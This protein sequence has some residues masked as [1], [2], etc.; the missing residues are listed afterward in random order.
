MDIRVY[1]AGNA[2]VEVTVS[3]AGGVTVPPGFAGQWVCLDGIAYRTGC[4]QPSDLHIGR[5]MIRKSNGYY[6]AWHVYPP[7]PYD[8][9]HQYGV[10]LAECKE[11]CLQLGCLSLQYYVAAA[12]LTEGAQS[13]CAVRFRDVYTAPPDV[14]HSVTVSESQEEEGT[15]SSYTYVC[16][17]SA[18]RPTWL[19]PQ[20]N[21][22][23][24]VLP[25][26]ALVTPYNFTSLQVKRPVEY[27]FTA[28]GRRE[29]FDAALLPQMAALSFAVAGLSVAVCVLL[30]AGHVLRGRTRR[31]SA[32]ARAQGW[33]LRSLRGVMSCAL[34]V[35]LIQLVLGF[36]LMQFDS[37]LQPPQRLLEGGLF[38]FV[39]NWVQAVL[40]LPL[41]VLDFVGVLPLRRS[42]IRHHASIGAVLGILGFIASHF[43][44]FVTIKEMEGQRYTGNVADGVATALFVGFTAGLVSTTSFN[45][46]FALLL[47][48]LFSGAVYGP[49]AVARLKS[50]CGTCEVLLIPTAVCQ[51]VVLG[52]A[53]CTALGLAVRL[54]RVAPDDHLVA[55]LLLRWRWQPKATSTS[56]RRP[57]RRLEQVARFLRASAFAK[58]AG[59]GLTIG[60]LVVGSLRLQG[61]T[62]LHLVGP[63]TWCPVKVARALVFLGVPVKARTKHGRTAL[64]LAA[65][66]GRADM[67]RALLECNANPTARDCDN[68]MPR[69]RARPAARSWRPSSGRS[70]RAPTW[71]PL[72]ARSTRKAT[73]RCT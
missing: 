29:V 15:R 68:N 51:G 53:V 41:L 33:Y 14:L 19:S 30:G 54:R 4:W 49:L 44:S 60:A 31:A 42:S 22:S 72:C 35:F 69:R 24:T 26:M 46:W 5:P 20:L 73:A 21:R 56:V 70:A 59:S 62:L 1:A 65:A 8:I 63:S 7:S 52:I 50:R 18:G 13:H 34:L 71:G 36:K 17:V 39:I 67:V 66:R 12:S 10:T 3:R 2:S 28:H 27:C 16:P 40:V 38:I 25:K 57:R 45:E 48:V 11:A 23:T 61:I 64:H 37:S 58:L 32:M 47:A 9:W 43:T 55:G 6:G